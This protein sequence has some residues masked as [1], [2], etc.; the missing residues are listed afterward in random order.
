M[1]LFKLNVQAKPTFELVQRRKGWYLIL[2][3]SRKIDML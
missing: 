2:L 1:V 3:Q